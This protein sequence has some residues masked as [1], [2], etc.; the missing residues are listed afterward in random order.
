MNAPAWSG[1]LNRIT[2]S[3]Y[4][5]MLNERSRME[6]GLK[7]VTFRSTTLFAGNERSRAGRGLKWKI[8]KDIS[9]SY[10]DERLHVRRGLKSGG[11]V[12]D[13]GV[14]HERSGVERGLKLLMISRARI[15]NAP[16]RG[17]D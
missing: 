1:D 17:E 2:P 16:T 4:R 5:D 7:F 14:I 15:M 9:V 12:F 6:R 8:D 13:W 3:Q 11:Y 10:P